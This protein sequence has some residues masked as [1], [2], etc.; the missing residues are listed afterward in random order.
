VQAPAEGLSKY[1]KAPVAAVQETAPSAVPKLEGVPLEEM[2]SKVEI[3]DYG[4]TG[5]TTE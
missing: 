2:F 4:G 3:A 5:G 1:Y